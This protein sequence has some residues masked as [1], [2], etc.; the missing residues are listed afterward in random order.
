MLHFNL[1]NPVRLVWFGEFVSPERDWKHLTRHLLEYEL[2]IVTEGVLYI[3][4]DRREY[5]VK[6]GEYLIMSP[7]PRQHGTRVCKCR[8][9]W[10]HF[11]CPSLPASVS[12]PEQ[13]VFSDANAIESTAKLLAVREGKDHRGLLSNYTAT[14][15]LLLLAEEKSREKNTAV[16][17]RERLCG[18]IKDYIEWHRFSDIRIGEIAREIG[19][20]EKY[21][22]AVFSETEG[23]PLKKYIE[24]QRL[25][26][27]KR[28]LLESDY[29]VAEVAYYLNFANPHNFSRFFKTYTQT[30]PLE[31]RSR[32]RSGD[33]PPA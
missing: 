30:T 33:D 17:V 6:A 27:A 31:W 5:T 29:T 3:A 1:D 8:F 18:Q 9:Y 21:L 23:L 24:Q 22:S 4:D 20:H 7:T 12:L 15:L 11:H 25:K 14:E 2:F 19:Y 13:G 28:L 10:L 32:M 16:T 26:E